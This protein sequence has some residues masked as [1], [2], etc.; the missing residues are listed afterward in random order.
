[1]RAFPEAWFMKQQLASPEDKS[2]R[3]TSFLPDLAI[4]SSELCY[5]EV[6]DG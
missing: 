2:Q 5:F 3:N 4:P 6:R 1:M